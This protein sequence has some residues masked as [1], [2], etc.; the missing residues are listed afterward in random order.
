MNYIR[1]PPPKPL[2]VMSLVQE[3]E[4]GREQARLLFRQECFSLRGRSMSAFLCERMEIS[5]SGMRLKQGKVEDKL[6][7]V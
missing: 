4:G 5:V 3:P 6:G 7:K 1:E 2:D